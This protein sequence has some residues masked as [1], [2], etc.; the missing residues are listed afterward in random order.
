MTLKCDKPFSRFAFNYNLRCYIEARLPP[1]SRLSREAFGDDGERWGAVDSRPGAGSDV[2]GIDDDYYGGNGGD[3]G[4]GGKGAVRTDSD[5]ATVLVY[6]GYDGSRGVWGG[7]EVLLLRVSN[8]G[9][10]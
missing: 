8:D 1:G 6:G 2:S 10:G 7:K 9:R 4:R 5:G 3:A